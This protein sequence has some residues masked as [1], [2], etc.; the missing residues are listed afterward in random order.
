[1]ILFV[2]CRYKPGDWDYLLFFIL[3]CKSRKPQISTE[4]EKSKRFIYSYLRNIWISQD[5]GSTVDQHIPS[6][7]ALMSDDLRPLFFW[8]QRWL[9]LL[10]SY[11]NQC[12]GYLCSPASFC[13]FSPP[14]ISRMYSFWSFG[15]LTLT[16]FWPLSAPQQHFLTACCVRVQKEVI[17][18]EALKFHWIFARMSTKSYFSFLLFISFL[19]DVVSICG[20]THS[21]WVTHRIVCLVRA[22]TNYVF[23]H[24]CTRIFWRCGGK[25]KYVSVCCYLAS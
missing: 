12:Y 19:C 21:R 13:S 1:M 3:C 25:E 20:S 24:L 16:S 22:Q 23:C 8:S 15:F 6:V 9:W 2:C 14:L 4:P 5:F 7:F 10:F 18:Q 11:F 17:L